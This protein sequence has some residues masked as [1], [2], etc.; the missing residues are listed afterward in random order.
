MEYSCKH[1]DYIDVTKGLLIYLVVVG[2]IVSG[3]PLVNKYIF[4]FHMPAFLIIS[5]MFVKPTENIKDALKKKV[6]RLFIPYFF[7]SILLGSIARGNLLK[8]LLG[9]IW[10]GNANT[11][12]YTF[13]YYYIVT[14]FGSFCLFYLFS[15]WMNKT[16]VRYQGLFYIGVYVLMH[17]FAYYFPER[18]LGWI[19]WNIDMSLNVMLYLYIGKLIMVYG[20]NTKHIVFI[21]LVLIAIF[22]EL[23]NIGIIHYVFDLKHH[24][25]MFGLDV[26]IPCACLFSLIALSKGLTKI[27]VVSKIIGDWG[28]GSLVILLLHPLFREINGMFLASFNEYIVSL[29]NVVE[30]MVMYKVLGSNSYTKILIGEKSK[31]LKY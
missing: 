21:S 17:L 27:P 18:I 4:W 22:V 12:C 8:Q 16:K 7:F 31:I 13:P 10:G 3:D 19:P 20:K 23:D 15:F 30:C 5:G 1:L 26:I 2:H 24:R 6:F 14:L 9:T 28:K 25:W 29:V 11:T